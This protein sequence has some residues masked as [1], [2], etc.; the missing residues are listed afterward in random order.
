MQT[1]PRTQNQPTDIYSGPEYLV[2]GILSKLDVGGV[3]TRHDGFDAYAKNG[4]SFSVTFAWDVVYVWNGENRRFFGATTLQV[5][6]EKLLSNV[7]VRPRVY[8]VARRLSDSVDIVAVMKQYK[9]LVDCGVITREEFDRKK[10]N[11]IGL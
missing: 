1:W 7:S 6:E 4:N 5:R 8:A 11:A 3:T 9:E 2:N 10:M